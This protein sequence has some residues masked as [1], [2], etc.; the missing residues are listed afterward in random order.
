MF[1]KVIKICL[2][3][4]FLSQVGINLILPKEVK[5]SEMSEYYYDY[6]DDLNNDPRTPMLNAIGHSDIKRVKFLAEKKVGLE[7]RSLDGMNMTPL[8]CAAAQG[9][10]QMVEI[11]LKA[12]ANPWAYDKFGHTAGES[13]NKGKNYHCPLNEIQYWERIKLHFIKIGYPETKLKPKEVLALVQEKRWPPTSE[14]LA[15]EEARK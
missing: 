7:E 14:N 13:A 12:G 15:S 2:G 1:K 10:W 6:R 9:S 11:L 3:C 5:G 8:I 4:L